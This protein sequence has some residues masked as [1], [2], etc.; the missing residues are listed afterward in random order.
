LPLRRTRTLDIPAVS[1]KC[2]RLGEVKLIYNGE[3]VLPQVAVACFRPAA[4]LIF[5]QRWIEVHTGMTDLGL[6]K[7]PRAMLVCLFGN[8]LTVYQ[9]E[10]EKRAGVHCGPRNQPLC[11]VL[12][13][14]CRYAGDSPS[15]RG[16]C[17]RQ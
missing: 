2:G 8:S 13:F 1:S 4:Y 3:W 7:A 14:S 11:A 6:M 16:P 15:D 12:L 9:G 17:D 10:S 5:L